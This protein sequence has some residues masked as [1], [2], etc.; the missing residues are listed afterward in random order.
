MKSKCPDPGI[1]VL[2]LNEEQEN[3]FRIFWLSVSWKVQVVDKQI[4][5]KTVRRVL[6]ESCLRVYKVEVVVIIIK[7][8]FIYVVALIPCS[9]SCSSPRAERNKLCLLELFLR[10]CHILR[11]LVLIIHR[12]AKGV[13][14]RQS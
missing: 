2:Q 10:I 1:P 11:M 7:L 3:R 12:P 6:L 14:C 8:F 4:P 13:F 9:W 5:L